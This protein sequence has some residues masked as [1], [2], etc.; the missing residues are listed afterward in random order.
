MIKY[1]GEHI[2]LSVIHR[3][4]RGT[5]A[6]NQQDLDRRADV[7]AQFMAIGNRLQVVIVVQGMAKVVN[8]GEPVQIDFPQTGEAGEEKV[9]PVT[10]QE[11]SNSISFGKAPNDWGYMF[12]KWIKIAAK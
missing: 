11:G 12:V 4:I 5:P 8:G 1:H 10:L 6:T 7:F 9:I 2:R 3:V